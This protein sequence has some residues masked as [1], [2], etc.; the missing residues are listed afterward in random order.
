[1]A[2][3]PLGQVGQA[4]GLIN[5]QGPLQFLCGC[6]L[7]AAMV[8]FGLLMKSH[9]D[10]ASERDRV[11]ERWSLLMETLRKE[12]AIEVA[13]LYKEARETAVRTEI[14]LHRMLEVLPVLRQ[15]PPTPEPKPK[16]TRT[17][18][19]NPGFKLPPPEEDHG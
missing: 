18:K 1:M 12:H 19:T 4:A 17:G 9:R 10:R 14:G 11:D 15:M 16:R 6:L 2:A 13:A 3:D 7:I 5:E 8:L